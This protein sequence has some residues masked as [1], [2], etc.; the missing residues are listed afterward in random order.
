MRHNCFILF[1]AI[2]IIIAQNIIAA[3]ISITFSLPINN[4]LGRIIEFKRMKP[5]QSSLNRALIHT[6]TLERAE[7][8]R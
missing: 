7:Y 2:D 3:S 5:T 1:R 4:Q 8:E 6:H